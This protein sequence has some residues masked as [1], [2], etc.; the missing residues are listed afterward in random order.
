MDD[1]F[2]F[3]WYRDCY[4]LTGSQLTFDRMLDHVRL[5]HPWPDPFTNIVDTVTSAVVSLS[6]GNNPEEE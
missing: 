1:L 4:A 6:P 2:W 5:D 3:R